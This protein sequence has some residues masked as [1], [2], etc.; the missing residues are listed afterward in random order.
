M[1]PHLLF[2]EFSYPNFSKREK[3]TTFHFVAKCRIDE[4]FPLPGNWSLLRSKSFLIT[5]LAS[6][7]GNKVTSEYPRNLNGK[8]F[9]QTPQPKSFLKTKDTYRCVCYQEADLLIAL[10]YTHDFQAGGAPV[11]KVAPKYV[12]NCCQNISAMRKKRTNIKKTFLTAWIFY[13]RLADKK[14][15]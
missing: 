11:V 8:W 12:H 9:S 14:Y 3:W 6:F 7:G 15:V 10:L 1:P 13:S 5:L 4:L 2:F